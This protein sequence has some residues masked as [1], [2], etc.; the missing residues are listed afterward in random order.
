M[1]LLVTG[2]SGFLGWNIC[3][4]AKK[5]WE[6]FGIVFSHNIEIPGV[7]ILRVDLTDFKELKRLFQVIRPDAVIHAAAKSD[8]NYCQTHRDETQKIN[9]DA[10]ISIASLCAD[11]LIPCVFT[12]T[13][14][15]FDGL[16]PPY[17]EEAPVCPVN[18]YGEQKV[19]AEK[20][21]F[22]CYPNVSICR[23][24]LMFG[25]PGPVAKSFVQPMIKA[26]REGRE[27]RLFIDEVRTPISV[28]SAVQGIFLALEKVNGILHLGGV[29]R[30]SRYDFGKLMVD[31]FNIPNARLLPCRQKDVVTA[32]PRPPDVSFDSAKA[33]VMG[34]KPLPLAEELKKLLGMV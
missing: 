18:F 1:K 29:E 3:Q 28:S 20:G 16:N 24:A 8:P 15:V 13:D 6:V 23:M 27:L 14:L 17:R 10:A 31:I 30:I 25:F 12:S 9:V 22:K 19:L 4:I 33:S 32:A 11:F 26:V 7:N 2:A 34:F 21:M 5:Q